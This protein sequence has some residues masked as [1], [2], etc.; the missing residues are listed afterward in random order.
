MRELNEIIGY[1][2]NHCWRENISLRQLDLYFNKNYQVMYPQ[3][4]KCDFHKNNK[5]MCALGKKIE[6]MCV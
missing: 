3:E 1:L 4:W 2:C 6:L 5:K